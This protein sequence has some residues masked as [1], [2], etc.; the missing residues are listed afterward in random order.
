MIPRRRIFTTTSCPREAS[1]GA[2]VDRRRFERLGVERLERG[3]V[4]EI[5]DGIVRDR[6]YIIL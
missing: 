2:L 6:R 1:R 4:D 5:H 3:L